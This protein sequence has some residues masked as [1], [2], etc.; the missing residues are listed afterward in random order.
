M[1]TGPAPPQDQPRS[2]RGTRPTRFRPG[3]RDRVLAEAARHFGAR[4]AAGKPRPS[5]HWGGPGC[6]AR[7]RR[8]PLR[9][10][11]RQASATRGCAAGR[12][13][14]RAPGAGV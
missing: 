13:G 6:A 5:W 2:R 4:R 9:R 14:Q 11:A 8:Q 1:I 3:H 10:G 7:R 12:A